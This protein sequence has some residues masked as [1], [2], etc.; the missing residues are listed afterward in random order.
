MQD[1][2]RGRPTPLGRLFLEINRNVDLR[3]KKSALEEGV[4]GAAGKV[5]KRALNKAGKRAGLRAGDIAAS[6][7]GGK[8]SEQLGEY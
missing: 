5:A 3:E 8:D 2:T 6:S 7:T 1:L 4:E